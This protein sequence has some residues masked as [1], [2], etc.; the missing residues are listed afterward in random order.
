[1]EGSSFCWWYPRSHQSALGRGSLYQ[2]GQTYEK[3]VAVIS[4]EEDNT[5]RLKF[6][7]CHVINLPSSTSLFLVDKFGT[8]ESLI[9]SATM[10]TSICLLVGWQQMIFGNGFSLFSF[11][12]C[13]FGHLTGFLFFWI[14]ILV[15]SW[16]YPFSTT[17]TSKS[18]PSALFVR[19]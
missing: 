12:F 18:P 1:M 10:S 19:C 7:R 14:C 6:N 4:P 16:S 17:T 15:I 2:F 5:R 8:G 9:A 3:N 11:A 13:M